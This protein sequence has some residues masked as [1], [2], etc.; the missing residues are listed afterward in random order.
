MFNLFG[1][2]KSIELGEE[3]PSASLSESKAK[4]SI[5]LDSKGKILFISFGLKEYF[6][7]YD[8]YDATQVLPEN[9]NQICIFFYHQ[10]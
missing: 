6:L 4:Y 2:R 7:I 10:S 1:K 5:Q 9:I 3:V 8:I